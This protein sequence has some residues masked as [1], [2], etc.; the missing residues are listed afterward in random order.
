MNEAAG[1]W[2]LGLV[3]GAPYENSKGVWSEKRELLG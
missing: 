3:V 1:S 2:N